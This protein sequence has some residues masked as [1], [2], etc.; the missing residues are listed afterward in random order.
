MPIEPALPSQT[1]QWH[2]D[3]PLQWDDFSGP[4]DP[5][6]P[7][8]TVAMT[9]ASLR[10]SY[11]YRIERDNDLCAY[12]I[13]KVTSDAVFSPGD[14]WVKPGY[15][16]TAVLNHEQGHFDLTQIFK[17]I[18]DQRATALIDIRN[19]CEGNTIGEV[20]KFT[21][22]DAAQRVQALFDSVWQEYLA[23]QAAYD[24]QTQHG[25]AIEPQ[26]LWTERI[27]SGLYAG[28]WSAPIDTG[29]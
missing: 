1:I 7:P 12:R 9:A 24:E 5:Y 18:L 8:E 21:K 13:S 17:R 20:S 15:K 22:R 25:I 10:W 26:K 16:N 6:S 29:I 2:A 3:R 11:E 28:A 4:I 19:S 23:A 27:Q 14:S